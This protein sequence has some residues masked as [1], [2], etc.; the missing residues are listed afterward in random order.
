MSYRR[1]RKDGYGVGAIL[2][3][4]K[5]SIAV[6][7]FLPFVNCLYLVASDHQGSAGSGLAVAGQESADLLFAVTAVILL[8]GVV[9]IA[10]SLG[11]RHA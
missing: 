4:T 8:V 5:G 6:N 7:S 2:S 3:F 11:K 10:L 9:V 1:C